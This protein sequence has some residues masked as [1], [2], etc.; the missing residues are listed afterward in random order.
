MPDIQP[1]GPDHRPATTPDP[2]QTTT[3]ADI[4]AN[5]VVATGPL[6]QPGTRAALPE[7]NTRAKADK[8]HGALTTGT[9]QPTERS[10]PATRPA[11]KPGRARTTATAR[12]R[13]AGSGPGYRLREGLGPKRPDSPARH[14]V[15][16]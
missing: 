10:E 15:R 11:T 1:P 16:R 4:G 8:T 9:R 5:P 7:A 14:G 12:T 6:H 2:S 3:P 13:P